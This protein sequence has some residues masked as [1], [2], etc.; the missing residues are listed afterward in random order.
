VHRAL[1]YSFIALL[2]AMSFG[3]SAKCEIASD[4]SAPTQAPSTINQ[5]DSTSLRGPIQNG[6]DATQA[7]STNAPPKADQSSSENQTSVQPEES[8]SSQTIPSDASTKPTTQS[9]VQVSGPKSGQQSKAAS[10]VASKHSGKSLW[11]AILDKEFGGDIHTIST[12][13]ACF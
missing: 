13:K 5:D 2:V 4:D 11:S 12:N 6:L 1:A 8:K 9:A 3:S 7:S 10:K